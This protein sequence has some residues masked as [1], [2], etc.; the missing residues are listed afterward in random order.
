[1]VSQ[2]FLREFPTDPFEGQAYEP[3]AALTG[4]FTKKGTPRKALTREPRLPTR[5]EAAE[6]FLHLLGL[7][8]GKWRGGGLFFRGTVGGYH[9]HIVGR[10]FIELAATA[11]EMEAGRG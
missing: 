3:G 4:L 6:N 11:R 8:T 9:R 7:E 2:A 5:E 1:M 10:T